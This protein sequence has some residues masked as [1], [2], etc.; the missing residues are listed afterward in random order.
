LKYYTIL[1]F[2]LIVSLGL[3]YEYIKGCLH[4]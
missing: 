4:W 2:F 3:W 1:V